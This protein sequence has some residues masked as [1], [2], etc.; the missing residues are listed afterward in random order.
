MIVS[1]AEK[2]TQAL[3]VFHWSEND[4]VHETD[5]DFHGGVF[6]NGEESDMIVEQ[7]KSGKWEYRKW[8]SGRAECWGA[9]SKTVYGSN[10][11]EWG[12]LY[13]AEI[14]MN[15]SY[16]IAFTDTPK[17]IATLHCGAG[18]LLCCTSLGRSA[19][20]TSAYFAVHPNIL[21]SSYSFL[22]EL[23]VVGKWK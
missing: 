23:Y 10:W 21:S 19:G 18:G 8:S 13:Q 15:E 22:L 16:P 1:S 5:V 9:F 20:T 4:F 14:I 12:S 2:N 11:S 6:V 3:P 7:G 17:E